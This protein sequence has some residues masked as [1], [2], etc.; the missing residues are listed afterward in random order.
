MTLNFE[1][2]NSALWA[3]IKQH[4]EE[5]IDAL[6]RKND[7]AL[8]VETTANVRGRIASYKELLAA[9]EPQVQ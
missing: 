2:R 1:E 6:R 8:D 4:A 5:R 9:S 7:G 3:K